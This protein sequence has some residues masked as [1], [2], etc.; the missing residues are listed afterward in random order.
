MGSGIECILSKLMGDV[1]LSAVVDTLEGKEAIQ[2]SL[3]RLER[4][5]CVDLMKFSKAKVLQTWIQAE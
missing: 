2:R 5:A 3:D 1:K 4:W